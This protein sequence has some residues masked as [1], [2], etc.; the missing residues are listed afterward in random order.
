MISP[1]TL[2]NR[3]RYVFR[4]VGSVYQGYKKA[5]NL[6]WIG[7]IFVNFTLFFNLQ[8][9]KNGMGMSINPKRRE[10]GGRYGKHLPPDYAPECR[11]KYHPKYF[12]SGGCGVIIRTYYV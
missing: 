4:C 8:N 6:K 3:A 12:G 11:G 9:L 1:G 7:H 10:E 5:K 2:F